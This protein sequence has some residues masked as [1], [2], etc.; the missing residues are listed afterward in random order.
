MQA[1]ADVAREEGLQARRLL[2]SIERLGGEIE[3]MRS[4]FRERYNQSPT[5]S[6]G[7]AVPP[8]GDGPVTRSA[9]AAARSEDIGGG[10]YSGGLDRDD[11]GGGEAASGKSIPNLE[12]DVE[13]LRGRVEEW[14]QSIQEAL[15]KHLAQPRLDQRKIGRDRAMAE[16]ALKI[17]ELE[18]ARARSKGKGLAV[19]E[20]VSAPPGPSRLNPYPDEEEEDVLQALTSLSARAPDKSSSSGQTTSAGGPKAG[21]TRAGVSPLD[22]KV[23]DT[24][25]RM[26]ADPSSARRSAMSDAVS[27]AGGSGA[28][29]EGS[30]KRPSKGGDEEGTGDST[31]ESGPRTEQSWTEYLTELRGAMNK[32]VDMTE[33]AK[34]N[35]TYMT[36]AKRAVQ[37]LRTKASSAP[38]LHPNF[39]AKPVS[40]S[41]EKSSVLADACDYVLNLLG[42]AL[43]NVVE[44]A[45]ASQAMRIL[46]READ[47]MVTRELQLVSEPVTLMPTPPRPDTLPAPSTSTWLTYFRELREL[48]KDAVEATKKTIKDRNFV[49]RAHDI[50]EDLDKKVDAVPSGYQNME[51]MRTHNLPGGYSADK[52]QNLVVA[53]DG[54]LDKVDNTPDDRDAIEEARE[55]MMVAY[56][57][58]VE[59]V[60]KEAAARGKEQVEGS[61]ATRT[62]PSSEREEGEVARSLDLNTAVAR[63]MAGNARGG[64]SGLGVNEYG[65]NVLDGD[66]PVV[67]DTE[68]R[69]EDS[70]NLHAVVSMPPARL[71]PLDAPRIYNPKYSDRVDRPFTMKI[72]NT[73]NDRILYRRS[74]LE[75][76]D[77]FYNAIFVI[78]AFRAKQQMEASGLRPRV[79][80]LKR[81]LGQQL[82][83]YLKIAQTFFSELV[84]RTM[85]CKRKTVTHGGRCKNEARPGRKTCAIHA[86]GVHHVARSCG[87][88][89]AR[90]KETKRKYDDMATGIPSAPATVADAVRLSWLSRFPGQTG[91]PTQEEAKKGK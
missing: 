11:G 18:A 60:E 57:E 14:D 56:N 78:K 5:S 10:A 70:D 47:K 89:V 17:K 79:E 35:R 26:A 34:G 83:G 21:G 33:Q 36:E 41:V 37:A 15:D 71:L 54:V 81:K 13:R 73:E 20:K 74:A 58:A 30:G 19:P 23:A 44:I 65:S 2:A 52:S 6:Q 25:V 72:P 62:T 24:L 51:Y 91:A 86:R 80:E 67:D 3:R 22:M 16:L 59:A 69:G 76:A 27:D 68:R 42:S 43:L 9:S 38:P 82:G 39:R 84:V 55:S 87:M 49:E 64:P 8:R 45:K 85:K 88:H 53:C 61:P 7:P 46:C 29:L 48:Q 66:N 90:T 32:A 40:D 31:A 50:L 1:L 75:G 4:A 28:R 12:E 77:S 63:A